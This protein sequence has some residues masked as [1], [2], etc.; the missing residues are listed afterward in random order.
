MTRDPSTPYRDVEDTIVDP[1]MGERMAAVVL[2]P[3]SGIE[4]GEELGIELA[5]EDED[6]AFG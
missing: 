6:L 2:E 1:G 4:L 3:L 5:L